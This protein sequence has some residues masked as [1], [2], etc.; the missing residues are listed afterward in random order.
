MTRTTMYLKIESFYIND[1]SFKERKL[2]G[3]RKQTTEVCVKKCTSN[4]HGV[5]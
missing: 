5:G 4:E 3:E 1:I 2:R